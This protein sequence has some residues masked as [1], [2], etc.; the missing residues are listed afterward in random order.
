[1]MGRGSQEKMYS[2][3]KEAEM[4]NSDRVSVKQLIKDLVLHENS[5]CLGKLNLSGKQASGFNLST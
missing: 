1:M 4:R 2:K 3:R 5:V